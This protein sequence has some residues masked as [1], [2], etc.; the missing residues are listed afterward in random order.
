MVKVN[1]GDGSTLAFD[2]DKEEDL[3]QWLEWSNVKDFQDRVTAIG[4]LH[5]NRYHSCPCPKKFKQVFFSAE[6]VYT[7]KKGIQRKSGEKV[8]IHADHIKMEL[9]V[10]TYENPL[11]PIASRVTMIKLGKQMFPGVLIDNSK[12]RV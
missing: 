2:L 4:I 3:K 11:P 10:Y 12:E 5:N 1:F 6:T 8:I 9:L 7:F